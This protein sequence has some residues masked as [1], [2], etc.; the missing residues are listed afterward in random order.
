MGVKEGIR[1]QDRAFMNVDSNS[2][3]LEGNNDLKL[4]VEIDGHSRPYGSRIRD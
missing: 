2:L 1:S 3:K 4:R